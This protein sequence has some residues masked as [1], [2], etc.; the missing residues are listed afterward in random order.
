MIPPFDPVCTYTT[1]SGYFQLGGAA[2]LQKLEAN[3][4]M[5]VSVEY[6]QS[7]Y[8]PKNLSS[9]PAITSGLV[10]ISGYSCH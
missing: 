8:N 9:L 7:C 5:Q 2:E 3:P 6:N 4:D 1:F 10:T